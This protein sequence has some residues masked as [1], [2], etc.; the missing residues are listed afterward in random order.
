LKKSVASHSTFLLGLEG[1]SVGWARKE[2]DR[3]RGRVIPKAR[4]KW[5]LVVLTTVH[6]PDIMCLVESRWRGGWS[7]PHR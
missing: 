7:A 2:E 1:R 4:K 6:S 3:E 5:L